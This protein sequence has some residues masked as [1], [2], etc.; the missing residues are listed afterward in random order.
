MDDP[1][2]EDPVHHRLSE[3]QKEP[4]EIQV[5]SGGRMRPT[6]LRHLYA[7]LRESLM[8]DQRLFTRLQ[9]WVKAR[10]ESVWKPR[11]QALN[12]ERICHHV[13]EPREPCRLRDGR[14]K[15]G[16][17]ERLLAARC[18]WQ[19]R[20][21]SDERHQH[22]ARYREVRA[23]RLGRRFL[24]V[25]DRFWKGYSKGS[26]TRHWPRLGRGQDHKSRL[27]TGRD[28]AWN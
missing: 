27:G 15:G 9:R 17:V 16:R 1:R 25:P 5:M 24:Q 2:V 12:A 21:P 28:R 10:D 19:R 23:D 6:S 11:C 18:S 13:C 7:D 20:V 3:A 14:P 4:S 22:R 8:E 26:P